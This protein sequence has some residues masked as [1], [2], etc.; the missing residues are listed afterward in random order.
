[1][2]VAVMVCDPAAGGGVSRPVAE[3]VP[4]EALPPGI[5]STDQV[6]P[7]FCESLL[8]AAENCCC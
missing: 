3:I 4:T 6:T 5:A 8:M 2:L 1:M 7:R